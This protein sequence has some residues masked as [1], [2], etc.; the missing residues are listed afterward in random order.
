MVVVLQKDVEYNY[1]IKY[2][3]GQNQIIGG[4]DLNS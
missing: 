3:P 2:N 4:F 1:F